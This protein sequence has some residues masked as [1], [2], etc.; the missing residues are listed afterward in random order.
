MLVQPA[1]HTTQPTEGREWASYLVLGRQFV[2]SDPKGQQQGWNSGSLGPSI[3][4]CPTFKSLDPW[5][6]GWKGLG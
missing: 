1:H 3:A 5:T 6:P 2:H 4:R